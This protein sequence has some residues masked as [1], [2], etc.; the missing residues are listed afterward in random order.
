VPDRLPVVGAPDASALPGL[1]VSTG[2]GARGM[3]LAVLCG[4]LLAAQLHGEP[5]RCRCAAWAL[6]P[7]RLC[8][9]RP[10]G[11]L[12]TIASNDR[13]CDGKERKSVKLSPEDRGDRWSGRDGVAAPFELRPQPAAA[14]D[15]RLEYEERGLSEAVGARSLM[16]TPG[17]HLS[18]RTIFR[19]LQFRPSSS[20]TF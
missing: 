9:G 11:L 5:C 12:E 3:T 7:Q 16:V 8:C 10:E 20:P 14:S 19:D 18:S 1:F 13:F 17:M 4:E 2:M 15:T 6:A